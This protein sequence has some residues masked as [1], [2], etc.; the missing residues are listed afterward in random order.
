MRAQQFAGGL[1]PY[2]FFLMMPY[3]LSIAAM[4]VMARRARYPKA[5]LVPYRR[6]ERH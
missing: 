6:G 3:L 5:L 2:Q 1:V 4:V